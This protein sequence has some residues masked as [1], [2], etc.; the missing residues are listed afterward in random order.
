MAENNL[1]K[2]LKVAGG[3]ALAAPALSACGGCG[4]CSAYSCC[5]A[6]GEEKTGNCAA[7][8]SR[9]ALTEDAM[10]DDA[11]ADD[12]MAGDA[13]ADDAMMEDSDLATEHGGE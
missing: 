12:T 9:G 1:S 4:A 8:S 11:M 5:A 13:M 6:S 2:F 3:L 10:A 7:D